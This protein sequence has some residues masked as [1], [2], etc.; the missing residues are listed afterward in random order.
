MP[1]PA[2]ERAPLLERTAPGLVEELKTYLVRHRIA[3]ESMIRPGGPEAGLEAAA[4]YAKAF[5]GLL[6]SLLTA[7]ESTMV[8]AG[9]GQT[10][11]RAA[12]G[13]S[14]PNQLSFHPDPGVRPISG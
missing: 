3:V 6:C 7:A 14:G 1:P 11:G 13:R 4:R 5:D 2:T 12:V 10:I 9:T 8:K